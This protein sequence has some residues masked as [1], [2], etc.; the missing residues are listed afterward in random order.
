MSMQ[1]KPQMAEAVLFF[2]D[3]GVCKEML[4][5]EFEALL[6]GLVRMPEYA[7]RQMHLAYVLINPRLQARAAVFFYLDFDEQG[8][9]DTGWNLPLRNLAERA[10]RGPDMGG[11]PIR[12]A[13]RS[14]CPVSWHQMHLWDPE[15]SAG[16]NHFVLI[17]D[18]LRR[19]QL[20]LL[21]DE[22]PAAVEPQRLQMAAE[23]QWYAAGPAAPKAAPAE[24]P[25]KQE[26]EQAARLA[27][28]VKQQ[29]QQLAA[30]ARQHEQRLAGLAR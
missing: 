27:Q 2:N 26:D 23:E 28:L 20:G 25:R 21:V 8:G 15:S 24:P 10:G 1:K 11:G 30:L 18:A 22:E 4:Y 13:C 6:D 29:R 19:N 12:L 3:S 16:R 9:A 17:R 14:Q 5:P 7:D